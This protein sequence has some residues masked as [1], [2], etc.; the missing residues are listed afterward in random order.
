MIELSRKFKRLYSCLKDQDWVSMFEYIVI[1]GTIGSGKTTLFEYMKKHS[2]HLVAIDS[3]DIKAEILESIIDNGRDINAI[4]DVKGKH[5]KEFSMAKQ[6][7]MI[8]KTCD[9]LRW[10]SRGGSRPIPVRHIVM[11]KSASIYFVRY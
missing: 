9:M 10:P 7:R 5:T 2:P 3:D 8:E 1:S 4:Y 6:N 11:N